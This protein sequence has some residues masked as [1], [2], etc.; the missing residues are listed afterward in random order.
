MWGKAWAALADDLKSSAD[1]PYKDLGRR[2]T[3]NDIGDSCER[4]FN[5][6]D[7]GAEVVS[8][9]ASFRSEESRVIDRLRGGGDAVPDPEGVSTRVEVEESEREWRDGGGTKMRWDVEGPSE[10]NLASPST[11]I[12]VELGESGEATISVGMVWRFRYVGVLCSCE[13]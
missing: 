11:V 2:R 12:P 10:S 5:I 1:G 4:A 13:A 6:E 8:N 7:V 3:G 9:E